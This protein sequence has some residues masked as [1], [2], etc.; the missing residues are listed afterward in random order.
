MADLT[1][2]AGKAWESVEKHREDQKAK[3]EAL[4]FKEKR[5][6]REAKPFWLETRAAMKEM[7]QAL[8]AEAGKD[9]LLWDSERSYQASI[10]IEA[11]SATFS[12]NF[13][14]ETLHIETDWKCAT[15]VYIPV[16]R[17]EDVLFFR[18]RQGFRAPRFGEA[19]TRSHPEIHSLK[20][21]ITA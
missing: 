17:D 21:R 9:V 11:T 12:A 5:I 10:R 1:E 6:K 7:C 18:G 2:W 8:N 3:D 15:E 19:N 16:L 4:V 14:A 20:G 13:D